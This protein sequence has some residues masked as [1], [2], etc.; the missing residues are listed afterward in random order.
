MGWSRI[1][2][3]LLLPLVAIGGCWAD[4]PFR[5]ETKTCD[6]ECTKYGNCNGETGQCDCP[7]GLAG[8][9]CTQRL[10]PACHSSKE[11]G[12][13]PAYGY[14]YPKNCWCFRQLRAFNGSCPEHLSYEGTGGLG[15][16]PCFYGVLTQQSLLCYQYTDRH[17]ADQLSDSP[18]LDDPR[19]EWRQMQAYPAI[20]ERLVPRDK[21]PTT[22]PTD[23]GTY[24]PLSQCP[25]NCSHRGWCQVLGRNRQGSHDDP[26]EPWCNCHG[27][28]EGKSCEVAEPYHC[29]RNCS[30]VGE[31]VRGWCHCQP[32]YWGHG[33]TRRKAYTSSVGWR[34]NHAEIKIYVYDMPNHV[35]HRREIDDVWSLIDPMYNAEIEFMEQLLGDWAVRTENPWEAAL[36]FVPTFAYWFHGNVG[37]P[38]F[39]IQYVTHYLQQNSPFWN[40][41]EGRNHI[42]FATNDRGMCKLQLAAPE[43]Q[44]SIKLVHFGQAPRRPFARH[45]NPEAGTHLTGAL[46]LPGHRFEDFPEFSAED[47][48]YE[49][50]V[51]I[52]PEKDVVAPNV[53]DAPWVGPH[54]AK[55]WV[56][57]ELPDGSRELRL[58]P[59]APQRT[60]KVLFG[61]YNR[62]DTKYSQGV[63]QTLHKMFGPGGKYDAHGPNA[64]KDWFVTGPLL[65]FVLDK[66]K[67]STFC[68][69]PT[70]EGWGIRLAEAMVTG[71][72]P[73][74]VQDHVYQALW[75]VLP[76]EDFSIRISRSELHDIV[77]ILDDVK[78]AELERLRAGVAK[79]H[80]AFLWAPQLGGLAY[81]YTLTA[82][83]RRALRLWSEDYRHLRHLRRLRS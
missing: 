50:E 39:V 5:E 66:M 47:L 78:P 75:D 22:W 32:G 76:Y 64:R 80:R 77:N 35:V 46:P 43:M 44:K 13:T 6:P 58:K 23:G 27:Y 17:E 60:L 18:P 21:W 55:L 81:N 61:G 36:F 30:G 28:Y 71:C 16:S 63:R 4:S 79:W 25:G 83:K 14:R 3:A 37:S 65:S 67:E 68:I 15:G 19:I 41:T 31:C 8:S 62:P 38:Y 48:M 74:I 2:R 59:E 33:C 56:E 7:F 49:H 24:L 73:V 52:R 69:A 9:N 57:V 45:N 42:F 12:T 51:C 54:L 40:V 10:L 29:Y 20:S 11:P 34:P 70:G 53:L 82:L 72:V 1:V 26:N